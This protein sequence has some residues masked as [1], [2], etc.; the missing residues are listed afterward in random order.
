MNFIL[1]T[2]TSDGEFLGF[3]RLKESTLLPC[4]SSS[5][6]LKFGLPINKNCNITRE[7][8]CQYNTLF[9]DIYLEY[10]D[11]LDVRKVI[12]VPIRNMNIEQVLYNYWIVFI[13]AVL[14]AVVYL[15]IP[16]LF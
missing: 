12:A 9:Y 2:Y 14:T 7:S 1:A 4:L 3:R 11:P 8:L 15:S 5:S 6:F 10:S 16:C 13:F